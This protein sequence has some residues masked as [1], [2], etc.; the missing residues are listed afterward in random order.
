MNPEKIGRYEIKREIGRGGMATVYHAYDPRFE[1]EV[2]VKVLPR[3]FLHDTMFL[4]RFEREAKTIAALEHPAIAS[5]YDYGEDQGQPYLVMRYLGGGSLVDRILA[6]PMALD[7][8]L[9]IIERIAAALDRAHSKGIIHRDVKPSNIMFDDY[10]DAYLSD[11]GIVKVT[12]AT[13]QLTGSGVVGTP[14]YMAPEMA[15]QGGTSPLIDL[16]A[17]GVTLF[18]MLTGALPY[19]ADTPMGIIMAHISK[20]VP[21]VRSLR[22][23]LPEDVQTVVERALA[24]DPTE[25]YQSAGALAAELEEAATTG[26][27]HK[28]AAPAA[29]PIPATKPA[30][31]TPVVPQE[32]LPVAPG[33][34]PVIAPE[35]PPL[36]K[37]RRSMIVLTALGWTFAWLVAGI[38]LRLG[39]S[40]GAA[41]CIAPGIGGAIGGFIMGLVLRRERPALG[42]GHVLLMAV[43]WLFGGGFT[44]VVVGG[45]IG[46]FATG[47]ILRRKYPAISWKRVAAITLGW[48]VSTIAGLLVGL[49]FFRIF[50]ILGAPVAGAV[51]GTLGAWWMVRQLGKAAEECTSE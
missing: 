1:R 15:D 30:T 44:L 29:A 17:L 10:G 49:L 32:T 27:T 43:G 39:G 40:S 34:A 51:D 31:P 50:G 21:D 23:D 16:Y 45:A 33:Q 3:E 47:F 2:A 25:R 22:S 11:F 9:A 36:A 46:G 20:P 8:A 4:A 48:T 5:V 26:L 41:R 7:E 13:S 6:G 12:E 35:A 38:L 28:P 42:W 14:A 19:V 24:K 18:Q 37:P